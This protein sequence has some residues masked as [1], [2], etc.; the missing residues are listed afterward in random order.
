[1]SNRS[2]NVRTVLERHLM[3]ATADS[4]G[5]AITRIL[6]DPGQVQRIVIENHEI[7]V[8]RSQEDTETQEVE[9]SW[10]TALRNVPQMQELSDD[11]L[12]PRHRVSQMLL[13]VQREAL[14]PIA[15]VTGSSPE[16]LY[17]WMRADQFYSART[18]LGIPLVLQNTI[19]SDTLLLCAAQTKDSDASEVCYVVKSVMMR[20]V[21]DEERKDREVAFAG[22]ADSRDRGSPTEILAATSRGLRSVRRHNG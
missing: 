3:P 13:M 5:A 17:T 12:A 21:Q 2:N 7:R 16:F 22:R 11:T 19:P 15:W 9:L 8:F 18:F 1:M 14:Q 10:E 6:T 20:G 4:I